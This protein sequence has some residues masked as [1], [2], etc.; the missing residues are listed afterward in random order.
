MGDRDAP[1][2]RGI[3]FENGQNYTIRLEGFEGPL[4]L[5]LHLIRKNH[6][7]IYDIPIAAILKEYLGV[8]EVM[9]ELDLDVAG[10]FLVMAATLAHIKSRLLLPV[11]E[12]EDLEEGEDPR[13]E[14]VRRLVEYDRIRIAAAD[15][16]QRPVLGRDVFARTW[17][18][19]DLDDVEMP[20]APLEADL[21]Q[22]L[23]AF[24]EM[25]AEAPEE[26]FHQ[27]ARQRISLQ[28]AMSEVL[29]QFAH[30]PAGMGVSFRELF[31]PR[32]PRDR[33]IATFLAL[34]EL[35]RSRAIR[36]MQVTTFGELQVYAV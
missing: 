24:R 6:F 27:V 9:R 15:L 29:D 19:A 5:L 3:L 25:M 33:V 8:L 13:A 36:V 22:L 30:L 31:P 14:L 26:V 23:I 20:D 17:R 32:P 21:Y 12:E 18:A 34:L 11:P 16:E 10:E 35:V 1:A 28:Q 2:G 7:D 4:D